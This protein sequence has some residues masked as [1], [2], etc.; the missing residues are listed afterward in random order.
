M[1]TRSLGK[2]GG[3]AINV[4]N[5]PG[6]PHGVFIG[7]PNTETD[8]L[9]DGGRRGAGHADKGGSPETLPISR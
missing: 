9:A 3:W 5:E 6:G 8:K 4:G 1:G 7:R 2:E